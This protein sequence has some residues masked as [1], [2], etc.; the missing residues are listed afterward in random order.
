MPSDDVSKA[1]APD[2]GA[3]AMPSDHVAQAETPDEAA[4]LPTST[5]TTL[6]SI[7]PCRFSTSTFKDLFDGWNKQVEDHA[8]VESIHVDHKHRIIEQ[9]DAL[10]KKVKAFGPTWPEKAQTLAAAALLA[11]EI[12]ITFTSIHEDVLM[13]HL[14]EG[15]KH[16]RAHNGVAYFFDPEG[17]WLMFSGVIP[18]GCLVRIKDFFLTLEGLYRSLPSQMPRTQEALL[19]GIEAH[20]KRHPLTDDGVNAMLESF[21]KVVASHVPRRGRPRKSKGTGHHGAD[22]EE[23]EEP[24]LTPENPT[25]WT[26]C[27]AIS[28]GRMYLVLSKALL[29]DR[30][31]KY[32]IEWCD[33][34]MPKQRRIAFKD[35]C[36]AF[37]D[38]S[39]GASHCTKEPDTNVYLFVK[40]TLIKHPFTDSV[41]ACAQDKVRRFFMQTFFKNEHAFQCC[42][43]ALGIALR[44]LNV[45]RCFW[46]V[47]P[48]G[49]GQ[50]LFT[51]HLDAVLGN[52]HAYLDTNIYYS[53]EEMRKQVDSLIGCVV[54]T[55]QESVEGSSKRMREDLYKKHV[56]ADPLAARLPYAIVTKQIEL[57]GWKRLELNS[58]I[59]FNGVNK[60]NFDSIFR[61]SLVIPHHAQFRDADYL[62]AQG[63]TDTPGI[64]VRDPSL[65]VFLRSGPA[66]AAT[67]TLLRGFLYERSYADCLDIMEAYVVRGGDGGITRKS[68]LQACGLSE[69][70]I[71]DSETTRILERKTSNAATAAAVRSTFNPLDV[72]MEEVIKKS[73]E[74]LLWLLENDK[75]LV[76]RDMLK[77]LRGV[78]WLSKGAEREKVFA[79]WAKRAGWPHIGNRGMLK[80]AWAPCVSLGN[81]LNDVCPTLA[82]WAE[83]MFPESYDIEGMQAILVQEKIINHNFN[84]FSEYYDKRIAANTPKRGSRSAEQIAIMADCNE[85]KADVTHRQKALHEMQRLC[86]NADKNATLTSTHV[87]YVQHHG[88]R[89]RRYAVGFGAQRLSRSDLTQVCIHT[90]DLDISNC[91]FTLLAQL[92]DKLEIASHLPIFTFAKVKEVA[93]DRKAVCAAMGVSE[94]EGKELLTKTLNGGSIQNVSNDAAKQVLKQVAAEGKAL[95]WISTHVFRDLHSQWCCEGVRK[96]PESSAFHHLWT[97]VE[98]HVLE[99]WAKFAMTKTPNHLSLHFDGIRI[100]RASVP[101]PQ[102][103]VRECTEHIKQTTGFDVTI[104]EKTHGFFLQKAK[105]AAVPGSHQE[106]SSIGMPKTNNC[107]PI[108]LAHLCPD[109]ATAIAK[110]ATS[111]SAEN[112]ASALRHGRKYNAWTETFGYDLQ[113]YHGLRLD[114]SEKILIHSDQ[115]GKPHCIAAEKV[116]TSWRITNTN[117]SWMVESDAL[118]DSFRCAMDT[119]S[120]VTFAVL[121]RTPQSESAE[122]A[123]T[124]LINLAAGSDDESDCS[125]DTHDNDDH[126]E[127]G[128]FLQHLDPGA[129]L[130]QILGEEVNV[131]CEKLQCTK[132][133]ARPPKGGKVRT[134][135]KLLEVGHDKCRCPL[136]P[137]RSFTRPARVL[138]H[139]RTYHDDSHR[140]TPSGLKQLRVISALRDNDMFKGDP[141]RGQYLERSALTMW[142]HMPKTSSMAQN[143][144][145]D[146]VR[147]VITANGPVFKHV[148]ALN[149]GGG[150]FH[151]GYVYATKDFVEHVFR[152]MILKNGMVSAI[153]NQLL[154]DMVQSGNELTSLLP[155]RRL[156]S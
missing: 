5:T 60:T 96:W 13:L 105:A 17:C 71:T 115:G 134:A 12:K 86:T 122:Q 50:S 82:T 144:V 18:T 63:L 69:H 73:D 154:Y 72:E 135:A 137:A 109:K 106:L 64:F 67:L 42:M 97:V 80:D 155:T 29:G 95:R 77:R 89:T 19:K 54:V 126:T 28:M 27:V 11:E 49:V 111:R 108:S 76:T 30:L 99:E 94:S 75:D 153:Y 117:T 129:D 20:V 143:G 83:Q 148:N 46:G 112:M 51:A 37:D 36:L 147:L 34:P 74:L 32:Y 15:G 24:D 87:Q 124:H 3:Q 31:L 43:A 101:D 138:H 58:L 40:H 146:K 1:K 57:N 141:R 33:V 85:A 125:D 113:P 48:G 9:S 114:V 10:L 120:V 149:K 131:W 100:D 6:P 91:A 16:L 26:E 45:D 53:D 98:D 84:V 21:R 118:M 66:V 8:D 102:V 123:S 121:A 25:S 145:D 79:S 136:C 14:I 116:Q 104:V 52:L 61:R 93:R 107:I 88:M 2:A 92:V 110:Q 56:S 23:E 38:D 142:Q 39:L 90:M 62:R 151:H 81:T 128:E 68:L 70:E 140:F 22:D 41:L 44:G 133:G 55:G 139:L 47:G 119:T 103:F 4:P 65:K 130:L 127:P 152:L 156:A 7:A 78:S 150:L 132:G 59:H 35:A